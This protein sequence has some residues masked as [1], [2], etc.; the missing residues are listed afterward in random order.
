MRHVLRYKSFTYPHFLY[1][2]K[3]VLS[4]A[5][6]LYSALCKKVCYHLHTIV[7][8]DTTLDIL[9]YLLDQIDY[10]KKGTLENDW[11]NTVFCLLSTHT[12]GPPPHSA[13]FLFVLKI[14]RVGFFFWFDSLCSKSK[15]T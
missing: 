5:K 12:P 11:D 9:E 2:Y 10:I 7:Q 1:I 6:L 13:N 8:K 14:R 15:L 4:M 3:Y